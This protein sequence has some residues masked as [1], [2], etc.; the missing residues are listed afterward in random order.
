MCERERLRTVNAAHTRF[1]ARQG[2]THNYVYTVV[3]ILARAVQYKN[4]TIYAVVLRNVLKT[5]GQMDAGTHT[6]AGDILYCTYTLA[7]IKAAVTKSMYMRIYDISYLL[8]KYYKE[9]SYV[10]KE[11][12]SYQKFAQDTASNFAVFCMKCS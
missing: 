5:D 2:T 8:Y 6:G 1:G 3:Y 10:D 7:Y 9:S 4:S 12:K 11:K